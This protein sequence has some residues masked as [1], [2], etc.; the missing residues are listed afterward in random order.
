MNDQLRD[1]L[2]AAARSVAIDVAR[3]HDDPGTEILV[4]LDQLLDAIDSILDDKPAGPAD[5][6]EAGKTYIEAKPFMAPEGL[7]VFRCIA[8]DKFPAEL[9]GDLIAFGFATPAYPGD[10]WSL[11]LCRQAAWAA[12]WHEYDEGEAGQ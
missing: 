12:G 11:F 8:V 9:D 1:R 7:T 3:D 2:A 5:F 10:R 6:F 4:D